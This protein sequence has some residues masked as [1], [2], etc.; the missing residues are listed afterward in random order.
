MVSKSG[1]KPMS[2]DAAR[3]ID[4]ARLA[5]EDDGGEE[6]VRAL[7]HRDDVTLARLGP[8]VVEQSSIDSKV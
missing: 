1:T 8:E 6:V 5:G 7:G 3:Q 2:R 4:Q